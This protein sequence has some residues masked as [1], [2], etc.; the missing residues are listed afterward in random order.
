MCR[1]LTTRLVLSRTASQPMRWRRCLF[2]LTPSTGGTRKARSFGLAEWRILTRRQSILAAQ[3]QNRARLSDFIRGVCWR[4]IAEGQ[5][6]VEAD[7]ST[8]K[9]L[10]DEITRRLGQQGHRQLRRM[11]EKLLDAE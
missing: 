6:C 5:A 7:R 8:I 10:E 11:L 2:R 9:D 4:G 1:S 3:R